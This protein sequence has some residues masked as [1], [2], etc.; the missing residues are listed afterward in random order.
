MTN[1]DTP[2]HTEHIFARLNEVAENRRLRDK[3]KSRLNHLHEKL[4]ADTQQLEQLQKQLE[5]ENMDVKKL[6]ALSLTA[7]FYTVL[8]SREQQL[9]KE[10]QELLSA[11]LRVGRLT[12]NV[13]ALETECQELQ[14]KIRELRGVDAQHEKLLAEKE[15]LLRVNQHPALRELDELSQKLA[16]LQRKEKEIDEAV[17]AA[18][19]VREGLADLIETLKSAK[20]W[21]TWDMLAGG[22]IITAIKHDA[23]NEARE[24]VH[25]VQVDMTKLQKELA[26]VRNITDLEINFGG[27]ELFADFFFD[28]LIMDYIIQLKI[29]NSLK[30]AVQAYEKVQ[31]VSNRLNHQANFLYQE[32]A[33]LKMN[34]KEIVEKA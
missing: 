26:D 5:K 32:I 15:S 3:L 8:G 31:E 11:Q 14:Q 1:T 10:R 7:L 20:N 22:L 29:F 9:E 28:S 4:L 2:P 13:H 25:Q 24:K 19:I 34:Y 30:K 6:E 18:R 33:L 21:G 23:I 12:H 27:L 17:T 16:T